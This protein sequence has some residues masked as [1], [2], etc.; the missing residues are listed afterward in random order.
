MPTV[1]II[2]DQKVRFVADQ[3]G[4]VADIAWNESEG[5]IDITDPQSGDAVSVDVD[6]LDGSVGL[7]E[8]ASALGTDSSNPI[9]GT[10]HFENATA[11]ALEAGS[12][13]SDFDQS[14]GLTSKILSGPADVVDANGVA[15]EQQVTDTVTTSSKNILSLT[16]NNAISAFVFVAGEGS[17][18]VTSQFSDFLIYSRDNNTVTVFASQERACD[19][20]TYSTPFDDADLDLTMDAANK[21]PEYFVRAVALEV[22]QSS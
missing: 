20:R 14:Q 6:L 12:I 5:R 18:N 4:D 17:G 22:A 16:N 2:G 13:I 10:T 8:L 19:G 11:D 21:A 1:R 9:P 3:G 15:F 7:A